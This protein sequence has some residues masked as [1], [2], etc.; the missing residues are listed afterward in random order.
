MSFRIDLPPKEGI[1]IYLVVINDV[2]NVNFQPSDPLRKDLAD[3]MRTRFVH[4]LS[5][6]GALQHEQLMVRGNDSEHVKRHHGVQNEINVMHMHYS[7]DEDVSP[8]LLQHFFD[9]LLKA[10][11]SCG[12]DIFIDESEAREIVRSFTDFYAN[13]KGTKLERDFLEERQLTPEE[14]QSLVQLAKKEPR[15]HLSKRDLGELEQCGFTAAEIPKPQEQ[16]SQN[17]DGPFSLSD[18][19][20][21]PI[22]VQQLL[23]LLLSARLS[24]PRNT[25]STT[26]SFF[27]PLIE[28]SIPRPITEKKSIKSSDAM[29]FAGF[30]PGFLL[31]KPISNLKTSSNTDEPRSKRVPK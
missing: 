19:S 4:L 2:I 23:L 18:I 13:F 28:G 27:Q 3:S 6:Q 30:K 8:Q 17:A 15:S 31:D 29:G 14:K 20:D 9:Q 12:G 10:Q 16:L 22:S 25:F 26:S 11:Q 1:F 24:T 21:L 7:F 5:E